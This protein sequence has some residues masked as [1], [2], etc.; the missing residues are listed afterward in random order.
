MACN[1]LRKRWIDAMIQSLKLTNPELSGKEI[2]EFVEAEYEKKYTEH[3][4][5]IYNSYENIVYNTTLGEC[6]D[7]I[8]SFKPLIAESG[9]FFYPKH[10]KRNLNTEIIKE[11]MLDARTI[12]KKEKF[13]ALDAGDV[14]LA[15]VKDI[16]QAN[17]KKAAN[18]GYGAEG[19][20]SSFLFNMHSAMSVT[21]CGRGQLS[22][23]AQ[24]V[25]NLLADFVK[26]FNMDEFYT[27][28]NH[29]VAERSNWK[30]VTS[31]VVDYKPS[32]KEWVARFKKKFLHETFANVED[33][34]R[35]YQAL[36]PELQIRTYY[37]ANLLE[38]FDLNFRPKQLLTKIMQ[39]KCKFKKKNKDGSEK[40]PFFIDPNEPPDS[41][42][43]DLDLL[44]SIVMEFINYQYGVFRYE[45]RMRYQKRYGI[46][47]S[48]TDSL[49]LGY[50]N[51]CEFLENHV[52]PK[53]LARKDGNGDFENRQMKHL[54]LINILSYITSEGIKETLWH[55]LGK[56]NVA[57]EDRGYIKMKNEYHY[58]RI[59]VTHAKKSYIGWMLRQESHVYEKP[60]LDVKGVNFF[61]STASERTS[62]FIYKDILVGQLL[63][64]K[65]GVVSLQ[66]TYRAISDFQKNISKDIKAGDMGFLKRSIKVKSPDA[67]ANPMRIGAFKATY[68]WNYLVPEDPIEYPAITT[69]VKVVLRNKQDVAKLEQWPE[70]YHKII[71]LFDTNPEI[72]DTIDPETGKVKKGKGIKTIALPDTLDEVPDWVLAIIDVETIVHDNMALFTQLMRPLSL[73]K[74]ETTHNG[75][76]M[77]Y[78]TNI[79]RI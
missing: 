51:Q 54:K 26:F 17:D 20:R 19:Q 49:M 58:G 55:Y 60:K 41:I 12:H 16:Q 2:K 36:S 73:A 48:D 75:S 76:S 21:S 63:Q 52:I 7:W 64:P 10:M 53:T 71:E 59:I 37:K 79:V 46:P 5:K 29:I 45:D 72:G 6:V 32:E 77:A 25:E 56:V 9:V 70:I 27:W 57:E 78:Y 43:D 18:S 35:V 22:T 61:K 65:D 38:F 39:T 24:G 66:R 31:D 42:K 44:A 69:Q 23:A 13:A 8:Q 68:V 47:V 33:I 28:I 3:D 34:H 14:F 62:D 30:Y 40:P 67:Y 1:F 50:Q 74:G 4:A 15:N 11:C